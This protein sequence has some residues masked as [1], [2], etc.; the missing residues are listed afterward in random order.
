MLNKRWHNGRELQ[1][2]ADSVLIGSIDQG[3]GSSRFL[4]FS[5]STGALITYHQE[6]VDIIYPR[7]GWAEANPDQLVQSVLSCISSAVSNL[8]ALGIAANRIGCI[9][10][11][12]QRETLVAWDRRT[13]EPVHP[14]ILWLDARTEQTV[15]RLIATTRSRSAAEFRSIC[16]LPITTYF[17]GV[18][19]RWLLDNVPAARELQSSGNLMMGT[20]DT[21]LLYKLTGEYA[22]DVTN[23]SRTM[24]LDLATCQWDPRLC[25]FFGLDQKM[26]PKVCSSAEL[27]GRISVADCPLAG[28]P[29]TGILGDQQA[30]LVGQGCLESGDTKNTYGSGCFMLCNTGLSPVVSSSGLLTTVAYQLGRSAAPVYALEGSVA[31][32][33]T[34]IRWLRDS[35]GIVGSVAETETL[36]GKVPDTAGC[37]FVPAFNGLY[38]PYWRSDARGLIVGLTGATSREHLC[39]AALEAVCYQS[40]ELLDCMETECGTTLNRIKVD[41]GMTSNRLL[42]QLQADLAGV[43]VVRPE[44]AETTALGAAVAAAWGHGIDMTA[45]VRQ[46]SVTEFYPM[47]GPVDRLRKFQRWLDAVQRSIGW[48]RQEDDGEGD[49]GGSSAGS[50]GSAGHLAFAVFL[51]GSAALLALS[52]SV[53]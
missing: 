3:T 25:R 49:A 17:T 26:L 16:G 2:D 5:S 53:K 13:G 35:L 28:V 43:T 4:V 11:A 47:T 38:C 19:I 41:G 14:A 34:A 8:A 48:H 44:M 45:S 30:A 12:N 39:R 31:V 6:E 37:Y 50:L 42:M 9:G 15:E 29:I 22:T 23:A 46:S 36:A 24:L 52:L 18:K 7:N 33:G 20:V 51:V 40:R 10:I 32:A 21:W 27:F 1:A